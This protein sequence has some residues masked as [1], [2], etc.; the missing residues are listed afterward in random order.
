MQMKN[1][2]ALMLQFTNS[3]AIGVHFDVR[4]DQPYGQRKDG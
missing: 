1:T 2:E 4:N 3:R